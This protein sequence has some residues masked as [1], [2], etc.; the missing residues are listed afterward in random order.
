ML[1]LIYYQF[2]YSK[3]QWLGTI[4][5]L[6]VSSLL[7]GMSV[8]GIR[9]T[10]GVSYNGEMLFKMFIFFGGVTLFLLV[11]NLMT[12]LIE[13]FKK[14]YQL[15]SILGASDIQLS[16]LMGAQLFVIAFLVSVVGLGL[17]TVSV[18]PYYQLMQL[19]IGKEELPDVAIVVNLL[20]LIVGSLLVP[21]IAGLAGCFYAYKVIKQGSLFT[22]KF[23]KTSRL[24]K[25]IS[26]VKIISILGTWL[27]LVY[28]LLAMNDI[29][30]KDNLIRNSSL[31]LVLLLLNLLV[32]QVVTPR[33]QIFFIRLSQLLPY[34]KSFGDIISGWQLLHYPLYL[35]TLQSSMAMGLTLVSGFILITQNLSARNASDSVRESIVS[36]IAY[37]LTP[38]LLILAN[39]ISITILSSSQE[40]RDIQQLQILGVSKSQL[41]V[42]HVW[43]GIRQSM[44]VVLVS[45]LFNGLMFLIVEKIAE[46]I[47]GEIRSIVGM[48][49]PTVIF[50]LLIFF[51]I[52]LTKMLSGRQSEE[53]T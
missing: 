52:L 31:T 29:Q 5:L 8:I 27:A 15:W 46:T 1:R 38:I 11:S 30:S 50:I 3:K 53:R 26:T 16:L 44:L 51:V 20:D 35:K 22:M 23:V 33:L 25:V 34:P 36:F 48:W 4:P 13:L 14:D 2:L 41:L 17:G 39:A 47:N 9:S 24:S 21:V 49:L 43:E 37:L 10:L 19:L 12:F 6:L 40:K 18:G 42:I 7:V 45:L 28:F 32:I